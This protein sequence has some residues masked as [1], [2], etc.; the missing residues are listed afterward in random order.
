VDVVV[1]Q[2]SEAFKTRMLCRLVGPSAIPKTNG[3][4]QRTP[5]RVPDQAPWPTSTRETTSRRKPV[6]GA[7]MVDDEAADE[8]KYRTIDFAIFDNTRGVISRTSTSPSAGRHWSEVG[9]RWLGQQADEVPATPDAGL[10]VR[11]SSL[12]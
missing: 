12:P 11:P 8:A 3:Q 5:L 10:V 9:K 4:P 2:C 6:D 7:I 1:P